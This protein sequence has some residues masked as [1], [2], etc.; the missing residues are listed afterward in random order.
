MLVAIVCVV[1]SMSHFDM[2]MG[3]NPAPSDRFISSLA[4]L[5]CSFNI[6]NV[7]LGT[8]EIV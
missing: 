8:P 5:N 6:H 3:S 1:Y 2:V 4:G 7:I